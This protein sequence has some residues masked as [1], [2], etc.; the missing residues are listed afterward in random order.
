MKAFISFY[1]DKIQSNLYHVDI[2]DEGNSGPSQALVKRFSYESDIV[3]EDGEMNIINESVF[4]APHNKVLFIRDGVWQLQDFVSTT[5]TIS[6]YRINTLEQD[7]TG[8]PSTGLLRIRDERR[9]GNNNYLDLYFLVNVDGQLFEFGPYTGNFNGLVS[10][11]ETLFSGIDG[12]DVVINRGITTA[13]VVFTRQSLGEYTAPITVIVGENSTIYTLLVTNDGGFVYDTITLQRALDREVASQ[14]VFDTRWI[15]GG[16]NTIFTG[17]G[18]LEQNKTYA[19]VARYVYSDGHRTRTC[20]PQYS[21]TGN[22]VRFTVLDIKLAEDLD[23]S[24]ADV[25]IFRKDDTGEFRFIERLRNVNPNL[26]PNTFRY[27]DTGKAPGNP[28]DEKIYS[29]TDEHKTQAVVRDRY[30]K[31]NVQYPDLI[32]SAKVEAKSLG[33]VAVSEQGMPANSVATIY[34][35]ERFTNGLESFHVEANQVTNLNEGKLSISSPQVSKELAIYAKYTPII[36]DSSFKFQSSEIFNNNVSSLITAEKPEAERDLPI[37]PH[38]FYGHRFIHRWL[39]PTKRLQVTEIGGFSEPVEIEPAPLKEFFFYDDRVEYSVPS[40]FTKPPQILEKPYFFNQEDPITEDYP[41][42]VWVN[43]FS[44]ISGFI[45]GIEKEGYI[46]YVLRYKPT[47]QEDNLLGYGAVYELEDLENL[48][49]AIRRNDV[50]LRFTNTVNILSTT[51]PESEFIGSESLIVGILDTTEKLPEGDRT[52]TTINNPPEPPITNTNELIQPYIGR[53][54][55]VVEPEST[56]KNIDVRPTQPLNIDQPNFY[57]FEI[58]GIDRVKFSDNVTTETTNLRRINRANNNYFALLIKYDTGLRQTQT[59]TEELPLI[60][61]GTGAGNNY[62][63]GYVK[64]RINKYEYYEL[65]P[66]NIYS[67]LITEEDLGFLRSKFPN[68]IIW[69]ESFIEGT[70]VSGARN[71]NPS[72]FINIRTEY[73]SIIKLIDFVDRLL[74]F[75]QNGLAVLSIGSVMTRGTENQVVIDDSRF[76]TSEVWILTST[77]NI[78]KRSIVKYENFVFFADNRDVWLYDGQLKNISN[79]SIPL[80]ENS[81]GVINP[82]Q[83]EYTITSGNQSWSYSIEL[84]EWTGPHTYKMQSSVF[85]A[86]RAVSVIDNQLVELGDDTDFNT[87]SGKTFDTIIESV[88]E[89]VG[90]PSTDKLFRKFYIQAD[91]DAQF[92]YT[93]DNDYT[94]RRLSDSR[95]TSETYQVGIKNLGANKRLYWRFITKVKDFVLRNISF[96][97]TPRNRR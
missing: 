41:E 81:V 54:Y 5:P 43:Y 3:A 52:F 42:R 69:S 61:L 95:K 37:N 7:V 84:G 86:D 15:G 55:L 72:S 70:F 25:E 67:Q 94:G 20:Y 2:Y 77:K 47:T 85:F 33:A 45:T 78:S 13:D 66:S 79:L 29:W 9:R 31:A 16:R 97:I 51:I 56:L 83:K 38:V 62:R 24:F 74:V 49:E 60:Y 96:E 73:G 17:S 75:T 93:K 10:E 21:R 64:R 28:L 27:I 32:S 14:V 39:P 71:F 22:N 36:S 53:V 18:T 87:Y 89:D 11:I 90:E 65:D 34:S 82:E 40:L 8:L 26:G 12:Y 6:I 30:V 91:G 44:Y 4:F 88:A 63:T 19:Y 57:N 50:K 58:T 1:R 59:I 46:P 68:Q 48:Q 76:L 92:D 80:S 35:R 23:G